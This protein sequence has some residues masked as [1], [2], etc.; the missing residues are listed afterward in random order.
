MPRSGVL[1]GTFDPIHFGH[2]FIAEAV[3]ARARLDRVLFVPVGAPI[4]FSG[5]FSRVGSRV[6]SAQADSA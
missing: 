2:L 1:G 4:G 5:A 3:R 6:F